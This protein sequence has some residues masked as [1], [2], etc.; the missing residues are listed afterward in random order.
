M[1]AQGGLTGWVGSEGFQISRI[2]PVRLESRN[3]LPGTWYGRGKVFAGFQDPHLYTFLPQ[4]LF[5][6]KTENAIRQAY[7]PL[8][9]ENIEKQS[10]FQNNNDILAMLSTI[11]SRASSFRRHVGRKSATSIV[12]SVSGS[13]Y[14]GRPPNSPLTISPVSKPAPGRIS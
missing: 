5:L 9:Q 3:M 7:N 4:N 1:A 10:M 13:S 12:A 11:G 14:R 6:S 2:G 8:A